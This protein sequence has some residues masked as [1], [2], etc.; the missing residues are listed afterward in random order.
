VQEDLNLHKYDNRSSKLPIPLESE[1]D[2]LIAGCSKEVACFLQLV[3]KTCCRAGEA[4]ALGWMDIDPERNVITVDKP[5]KS[6]LQASLSVCILDKSYWIAE[7]DGPLHCE[8]RDAKGRPYLLRYQ[9]TRKFKVPLTMNT[10]EDIPAHL[11][12]FEKRAYEISIPPVEI[13]LLN[14]SPFLFLLAVEGFLILA[15]AVF[16]DSIDS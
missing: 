8:I 10:P 2:A 1:I 3:K 14:L 15:S 5:E 16:L 13:F 9:R 7:I 4:G 11:K 6:R 12:H